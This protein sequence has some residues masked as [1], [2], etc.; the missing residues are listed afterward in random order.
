MKHIFILLLLM[1]CLISCEKNFSEI[2]KTPNNV[3]ETHPQ[4]LLTA[5][6]H[7][8]FKVKGTSAMYAARMLVATDGENSHQYYKWGRGNF[9]D[10][11]QLR[12]V[13]KML[14]EAKRIKN[15][16]YV[17]IAKFFRAY[18]F[19]NLARTFG[20]VPY[21]QALKG[22]SEKIYTPRYDSQKEVILGVLKTLKS[23][24][25][26]LQDN[27]DV[28]Q[29]DIIYGG[30]AQKWRRLVNTFRL[31]VLLS[32]S[33][34]TQE[35]NVKAEFSSIAANQPI[36]KSA[37]DAGQLVFLDQQD[38]RYTE[39]NSSG[40]GSG[41]Y[42]SD[43]FIELLKARKDPR[44]FI[45]SGRTRKGKEGGLAIDDFEAY[46]GGDPIVPYAQVGKEA[47][48]GLVSKVNLRY[49]T[50]PT[51]EPHQLLGYAETEFML[52]EAATRAWISTNPKQHYENAIK[53]SFKFYETYAKGYQNYVNAQNA[54]IY[55]KQEK[56][57]F[58]K[59]TTKEEKLK[60]ILTQKYFTTFL[61]GGWD[62]YFDYLRTGYPHFSTPQGVSAPKRWIYPQSEYNDN[63][64]QVAKAIDR[65]FGAG[66]DKISE[67]TW[68]LK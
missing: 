23:A 60:R 14:E 25:D 37:A 19:F 6:L 1:C 16:T 28:V 62:A 67:A 34:K 13:N 36:I 10:Y 42:M 24:N 3:S 2:N 31:K 45:F 12:Q 44:L 27:K 26:L 57:D 20:D 64:A 52:A 40:Y 66:N 38:S 39:F 58:A 8:A 33:K 21:S 53:A 63:K 5:I 35:V 47:E 54:E 41:M 18:Y 9:N 4:P 55:L 29:G 61:Q 7:E 48:E 17:A 50:D 43:T 49:T 22:E 51:T 11:D 46:N 30:S 15:D 65:Q 59:A 56:V 68:W 32:L